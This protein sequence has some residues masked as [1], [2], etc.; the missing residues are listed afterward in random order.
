MNVRRHVPVLKVGASR[1][2][3]ANAI[4]PGFC[5]GISSLSEKK[6]KGRSRDSRVF[7]SQVIGKTRFLGA[8]RR[9]VL[10]K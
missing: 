9:A 10:C 6:C 4:Q 3:F 7:V 2:V 1:G 5:P 8:S